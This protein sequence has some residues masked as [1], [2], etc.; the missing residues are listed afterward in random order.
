M[1][2]CLTT[3]TQR[4]PHK[5]QLQSHV[6]QPKR[7]NAESAHRHGQDINANYATH[8]PRTP[9]SVNTHLS[10]NISNTVTGGPVVDY[11]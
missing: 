1:T 9:A 2:T 11:T 7:S 4:N 8:L 6:D 3:K 5:N 10:N